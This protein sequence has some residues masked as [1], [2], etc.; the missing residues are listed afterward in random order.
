MPPTPRRLGTGPCI[1]ASLAHTAQLDRAT[2][3]A[4]RA[5]LDEAFGGEFGDA[6]WDHALGG[7]H[8][9]VLDGDRP[10]AHGAVVQRRLLHRG[11]ALRAGYVE[12]VA[13]AAGHRRQGLGSA[14]MAGLEQVI[15]RAYDLGALSATGDG[16]ALYAARGWQ[17]WR[18][19]ISALTPSGTVR[20]PYEDGA[21]HV[22]PCAARLDLTGELTAD[23]RDGDL[24]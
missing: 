22:L 19:P 8:A 24:W 9:L 14:V 18:G 1:G 10:V 20:T 16:A 3:A 23:W 17:L 7:L 15:Q 2:L 11:R 5:L 21:L 4:V 6:D 12:A 13:V